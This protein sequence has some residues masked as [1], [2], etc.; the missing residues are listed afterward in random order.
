MIE[1][2]IPEDRP[3]RAGPSADPPAQ[4]A[5]GRPTVIAVGGDSRQAVI[6][7]RLR[8][9]GYGVCAVGLA[10]AVGLPAGV[11]L[12]RTPGSC[13]EWG[14]LLTLTG[15]CCVLLLPLPLSRDGLTVSCPLDPEARILLSDVGEA[16]GRAGV[17]VLGGCMPADFADS[18]RRSLGD[19]RVADYY[20]SEAVQ[21]KNARLTAEGAVMTVMEQTDTALLG[22]RAAVI[23]YGRI[24]RQLAKLLVCLGVRVTVFARRAESLAE[25][26]GD[27]C[28]T[29]DISAG[30]DALS[31]LAHGYDV[32][33][34][35]V[36]ACLLD[37]PLLERM[38]ARTRIIDLASSPGCIPPG[39]VPRAAQVVR[40]LSLP[41][42]YAPRT[43]GEVLAEE[44]LSL[45]A[46]GFGT[47]DDGE[48][49]R[50]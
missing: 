36:P 26:W 9:E 5:A 40:A 34:N 7:T 27:G 13:D 8:E 35:T 50:R 32:I 24:G 33:L 14:R 2:P 12:L 28:G 44:V 10:Q 21:R 1:H 3:L 22:S 47:S 19:E 48:E 43:A 38:D 4:R 31:G 15:P 45:L 6:L 16:A 37:R 29:V 39:Y 46:G 30:G 41:G 20:A 18:L 25:A 49:G 23:G 17:P 42:R 11:R